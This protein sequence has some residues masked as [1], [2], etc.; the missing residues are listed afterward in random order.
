[1]PLDADEKEYIVSQVVEILREVA[2]TCEVGPCLR[3]VVTP[4][5]EVH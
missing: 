4:V 1:M 5:D 2:G 3:M